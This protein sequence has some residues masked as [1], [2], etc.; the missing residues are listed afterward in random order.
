MTVPKLPAPQE[1]GADLA[2]PGLGLLSP[3]RGQADAVITP[4]LWI[5]SAGVGQG[6]AVSNEQYLHGV[7]VHHHAR[8]RMKWQNRRP[9]CYI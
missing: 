6:L 3:P 5:S 7:M 1:V 4:V 9:R 2:A 8:K